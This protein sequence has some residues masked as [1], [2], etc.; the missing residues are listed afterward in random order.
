MIDACL[1]AGA[2][3]RSLDKVRRSIARLDFVAGA[4]ELF[5]RALS[6]EPVP[7]ELAGEIVPRMYDASTAALLSFW[8][9]VIASADDVQLMPLHDLVTVK[10]EQL[11]DEQLA[12]TMERLAKYRAWDHS[13]RALDVLTARMHLVP[14]MRDRL[15]SVVVAGV[16]RA[17][18]FELATRNL[19]AMSSP[20]FESFKVT[21]L[22]AVSIAQRTPHA[23]DQLI[24]FCQ[25]ALQEPSGDLLESLGQSVSSLEPA[26]GLILQRGAVASDVVDQR[27]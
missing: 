4:V 7:I 18:R 2:E 11:R 22:L 17:R 25:R 21:E 9:K 26:L 24:H 16:I 19:G 20:R 8:L 14:E 10:F 6:D 1:A 15:R 27:H 13:Q 12:A 3:A 5:A 23:L